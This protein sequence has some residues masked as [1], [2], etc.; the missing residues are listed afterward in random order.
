[1]GCPSPS[2]SLDAGIHKKEKKIPGVRQIENIASF[3]KGSIYWNQRKYTGIKGP[4]VTL[5]W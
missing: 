1:M 2:S 4:V 5:G 3:K